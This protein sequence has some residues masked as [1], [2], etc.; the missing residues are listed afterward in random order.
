[1]ADFVVTT[2]GDRTVARKLLGM[3]AQ[4]EDF[5]NAW[6]EVVEIAA[7]GYGRSFELEGP[8]WAQLKESTIARKKGDSRI[9]IRSGRDQATMSDPFQLHWHGTRHTVDIEAAHDTPAQYHQDGTSRMVA[10]PL[11][12]TRYYQDQISLALKMSLSEAYDRG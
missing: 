2:Y 11:M 5:M 1:M 4:A 3:A 10:R 6:P 8:G 9:R 7:R 12:L